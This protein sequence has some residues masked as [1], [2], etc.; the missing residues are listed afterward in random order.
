MLNVSGAIWDGTAQLESKRVG[1]VH[2]PVLAHETSQIRSILR[3]GAK[4][5][6]DSANI[7][8]VTKR[9]ISFVDH[10]ESGR[11]AHG[12]AGTS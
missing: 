12:L 9:Q 8:L 3:I 5:E 10:P 11:N 4:G 7:P 1:L 6:S 2:P